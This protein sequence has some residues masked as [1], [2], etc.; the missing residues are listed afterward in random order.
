M[1][2]KVYEKLWTYS[3]PAVPFEEV[4][5]LLDVAGWKP[6]EVCSVTAGDHGQGAHGCRDV[7]APR[8]C[9]D[10]VGNRSHRRWR[11][12]LKDGRREIDERLKLE[13]LDGHQYP[14]AVIRC[15]T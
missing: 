6:R 5:E 9:H 13:V 14:A 4:R 8:V 1:V 2:A 3:R 11:H 12:L 10:V 15:T 7:A